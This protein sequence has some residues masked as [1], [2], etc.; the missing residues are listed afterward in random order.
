MLATNDYTFW[1]AVS[2]GLCS[3][4][5]EAAG[6]IPS[7]WDC[8]YVIHATLAAL[9]TLPF[10]SQIVSSIECFVVN[11]FLSPYPVPGSTKPVENSSLLPTTY[12]TSSKDS[13][14]L[15]Y[16]QQSRLNAQGLPETSSLPYCTQEFPVAASPHHGSSQFALA[17]T[18]PQYIVLNMEGTGVVVS[19]RFQASHAVM[20]PNID[21]M[22][23]CCGIHRLF[24]ESLSFSSAVDIGSGSGFVAKFIATADPNVQVTAMDI[25]DKAITFMQNSNMPT[26][27][28]ILKQDATEINP[29]EKFDLVVSNPP[30]VPTKEETQSPE[31]LD[32]QDPNFWKGTGLMCHLMEQANQTLSPGRHLVLLVSSLALKSLR[33]R[34]FLNEGIPHLQGRVLYQQEVAYKAWFA[35][36]SQTDHLL[37]SE[38]EEASPTHFEW[39]N[40]HLFVGAT[41]PGNPRQCQIED[42]RRECIGYYWQ[43]I[44]IIDFSLKNP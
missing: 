16:W 43:M 8:R 33:F 30:Y 13:F 11:F 20:K 14:M 40:L 32:I 15:C 31:A 34:N 39:L 22:L 38:E 23:L 41:K 18:T 44:Y 10:L 42:G 4:H 3:A 28:E 19:M 21:T 24:Q 1:N 17:G 29:F 12:Y 35:G 9:E 7:C 25:E 37:A 36:D 6:K 26:N 5:Y 2:W 27:V